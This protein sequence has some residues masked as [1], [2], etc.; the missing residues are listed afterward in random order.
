MKDIKL[1]RISVIVPIYNVDKYI[2]RC[3][4]SIIKQTYTNIEIILV[5]DESPDNCAKICDEYAKKDSRIKVIHK[6]NGGLSSARNSGLDIA[7]GEYILFV[8]GDDYIHESAVEITLREAICN[9]ADIV[10]FNFQSVDEEGNELK[11][12]NIDLDHNKLLNS[13]ETICGYVKEYKI[14]VMAWNKLYRSKLFEDLRFDEGYVYEDE[15]IFP[16]IISKSK[17]NYTIND[18][19]YYYVNA[20]NSITKSSLTKNKV[21]SKKYLVKFLEEFYLENHTELMRHIYI[22]ICFICYN[23][24][25]LILQSENLS[26]N[27]KKQSVRYFNGKY[28]ESYSKLLKY[29]IDRK[30][31]I[32]KE[33]FCLFNYWITKFKEKC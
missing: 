1:P 21:E 4:E 8:D 28:I 32:K 20:P 26:E 23:T 22:A 10:H 15:L 24:R 13:Y 25:K 6:K 30:I 19:L 33:I 12:K 9:N 14:K 18:K 7:S 3:V 2:E 16:K 29:K 17:I 27:Y 11:I 31:P 5:D